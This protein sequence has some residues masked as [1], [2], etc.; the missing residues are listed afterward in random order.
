VFLS[1][2][3]PVRCTP[4]SHGVSYRE[5]NAGKYKTQDLA[6]A[7]GIKFETR[8]GGYSEGWGVNGAWYDL[9]SGKLLPRADV[10]ASFQFVDAVWYAGVCR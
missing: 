9:H 4:R 3:L 10:Y 7:C 5:G 1:T 6:R 2:P 8:G